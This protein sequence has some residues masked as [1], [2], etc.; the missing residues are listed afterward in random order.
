MPKMA[1]GRSKMT[2]LQRK[3]ISVPST[4]MGAVI[5]RGGNTIRTLQRE[6]DVRIQ[7]VNSPNK[8]LTILNV[9]A[10]LPDPEESADRIAIAER[11][12]QQILARAA[13]PPPRSVQPYVP[14]RA[15]PSNNSEYS[16]RSSHAQRQPRH[17]HHKHSQ[18][19]VNAAISQAL[20]SGNPKNCKPVE[21]SVSDAS[22]VD[23]DSSWTTVSRSSGKKRQ[24]ATITTVPVPD[25][26][27][28]DVSINQS[29]AIGGNFSALDGDSSASE[30]DTEY[31]ALP[32]AANPET[33]VEFTLQK[34]TLVRAG[35]CN[36]SENVFT[37]SP[38]PQSK[39]ASNLWGD[40]S[41]DDDDD[42]AQ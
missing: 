9:Q 2:T 42:D 33:L 11:R 31:P 5:G 18:N 24:R 22:V 27:S 4:L 19:T 12:I 25:D 39:E 7:Y 36:T 3:Q 20:N 40:Y 21:K 30:E 38:Q 32:S 15:P 6:L 1:S 29:A 14:F 28:E 10:N 35:A 26:T 17:R 37:P 13:P 23:D 34:P 41:S 16:E 8:P